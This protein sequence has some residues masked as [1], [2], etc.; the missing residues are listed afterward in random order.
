DSRVGA[1][2]LWGIPA[3]RVAAVVARLASP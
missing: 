3:D 2:Q 1:E